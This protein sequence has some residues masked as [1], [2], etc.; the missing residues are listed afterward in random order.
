MLLYYPQ[1]EEDLTAALQ[2]SYKLQLENAI[3][4]VETL[5]D[6]MSYLALYANYDHIDNTIAVL[7][8]DFADFSFSFLVYHR[9]KD[10][11]YRLYQIQ[12]MI[13]LDNIDL[14]DAMKYAKY[15]P[16]IN[17]GLI[18]HGPHMTRDNF[19]VSLSPTSGWSIHT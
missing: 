3:P 17:G 7:G 18:Y 19:T 13:E 15:T 11:S 1:I 5:E 16:W 9:S 4:L 2:L 6:R 14:N 8:N 12:E 10:S